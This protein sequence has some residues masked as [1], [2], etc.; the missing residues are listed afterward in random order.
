MKRTHR[1]G[2][3]RVRTGTKRGRSTQTYGSSKVNGDDGGCTA[4][5]TRCCSMA[6]RNF[7]TYAEAQRTADAHQLDGYPDAPAIDDG[8]YWHLDPE[9]DWRSVPDMSRG[10]LAGKFWPRFRGPNQRRRNR[11]SSHRRATCGKVGRY[12][13]TTMRHCPR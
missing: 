13:T 2:F 10:G 9:I 1:G 11:S 4:T 3:A 5:T 6:G 8:F 12:S 7:F